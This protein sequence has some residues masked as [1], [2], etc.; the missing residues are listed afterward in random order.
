MDKGKTIY[1]PF[2]YIILTEENKAKSLVRGYLWLCNMILQTGR[3]VFMCCVA[4]IVF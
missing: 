3:K 4:D 2:K 1:I